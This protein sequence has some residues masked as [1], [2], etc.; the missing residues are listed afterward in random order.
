MRSTVEGSSRLS[1]RAVSR[2]QGLLDE[3]RGEMERTKE[4]QS[5]SEVVGRT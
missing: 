4:M 5:E 3:T 2:Q 1:C